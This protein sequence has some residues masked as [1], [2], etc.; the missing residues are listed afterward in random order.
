MTDLRPFRL[1]LRVRYGEC[2]AQKVVYNARYAEYVDVAAAEFLR[3]VWG[4]AMFG[5]GLDYQLVKLTIEWRG[6]ARFDEVVDIEV[7]TARL[8]TTSFTLA[9]DLRTLPVAGDGRSVLSAEVVYVLCD[10]KEQKK[11]AIPAD[12]RAALEAGAPGTITDFA[13]SRS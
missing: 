1:L 12:R 4:T 9:M 13:G 3:A 10:D 11:M 8:G 6:S 7:K 5:G 2:D